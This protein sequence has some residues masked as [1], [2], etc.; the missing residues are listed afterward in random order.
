[1]RVCVRVF[2]VGFGPGWRV[3]VPIFDY[4]FNLSM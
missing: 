3:N 2:S 1:M 4:S